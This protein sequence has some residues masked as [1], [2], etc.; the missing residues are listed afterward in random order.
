MIGATAL[1]LLP[2]H[3]NTV[4]YNSSPLDVG[5]DHNEKQLTLDNTEQGGKK[6]MERI[7]EYR[8]L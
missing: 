1:P 5:H 2:K 6:N 7:P 4:A 8:S 3:R